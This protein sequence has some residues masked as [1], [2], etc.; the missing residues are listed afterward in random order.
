MRGGVG[1]AAFLR[2][3]AGSVCLCMISLP[4]LCVDA[5]AGDHPI[6]VHCCCCPGG[7]LGGIGVGRGGLW[8]GRGW[9][10]RSG[11]G[12]LWLGMSAHLFAMSLACCV[13]FLLGMQEAQGIKV[14]HDISTSL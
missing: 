5:A 13:C 4:C 1:W 2:E 11:L 10:L 7:L 6:E 3:G 8:L 14:L 12:A 9:K